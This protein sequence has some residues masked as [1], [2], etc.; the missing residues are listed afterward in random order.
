MSRNPF[1]LT[2]PSACYGCPL[3]VIG[4]GFSEPEGTGVSGVMGIGEALGEHEARDGYPF[5]P[6]AEAGSLLNRACGMAQVPRE[7]LS[8][9][10]IIACRPPA[11]ELVGAGYEQAAIAHCRV[12][13]EAAIDRYKPKVLLALGATAARALTGLTGDRLTLEYIRGFVLDSNVYQN[14]TGSSAGSHGMAGSSVDTGSLSP[15]CTP[16]IS[17]YHPSFI[18]RSNYPMLPVL[19]KDIHDAAEVAKEV[20]AWGHPLKNSVKELRY[21]TDAQPEDLETLRDELKANPDIVLSTDAETNYAELKEEIFKEDPELTEVSI[22]KIE[23]MRRLEERKQE[24]TQVNFS[25]QEGTAVVA[26]ATPGNMRLVREI[27][28]LPNVKAGHNLWMFDW[29]VYEDNGIPLYGSLEDTEDTMWRFHWLYPDLPGKRGK[30]NT[31]DG[32]EDGSVANLQFCASFYGFPIPW[33]HLSGSD[34]G[35]YGGCDGDS[36]LRVFW[37]TEQDMLGLSIREAYYKRLPRL[38]QALR[39]ARKRGMPVNAA[40]LLALHRELVIDIGSIDQEIQKLAPRDVLPLHPATGLKK[41]PK[42]AEDGMVVSVRRKK[43]KETIFI[44]ATLIQIDVDLPA[45]T[46]VCCM[47]ARKPARKTGVIDKKYLDHPAAHM[48]GD[49][50]FSPTPNCKKCGGSGTIALPDRTERRWARELPFNA[51]SP[52]QMWDYVHFRGY[53]VGKNS[54]RKFAMDADTIDKLARRYKDPIFGLCGK[55]RQYVKL[56]TTYAGGWMPWADGRVHSQVGPY[57]ASGQLAGRKPNPQN[58]PSLS[59]IGDAKKLME[60]LAE[61]Q[62]QNVG[63]FEVGRIKDKIRQL[64]L[65]TAFRNALWAEAGFVVIEGD[66]GGFHVGTLGFEAGD[67]NYIRLSKIDIHSFFAVVGLL[68]IERADSLLAMDDAELKAKLKWYRKNYTL[69]DG[70]TS[71]ET[72]RNKQAKVA[73]LAYGLGQGPTS[74]FLQNPDSFSGPAEADRVT[75][76]MNATF[77]KEREYRETIP[78]TVKP[79]GY[80]LVNRFGFIRWLYDVQRYDFRKGEWK[81]GDDWEKAIAFN[82]QA[83]AHGHLRECIMICEDAGYNERYGF[84]NTVHDS[85]R[86]HCHESLADECVQNVKLVMEAPSDVML[87]GWDEGRG[88]TFKAE[89]KMGKSWGSD[90]REVG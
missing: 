13:L 65:A 27:H 33:K 12:H 34:P 72:L 41:A 31:T 78:L 38:M 49:V 48:R 5:R 43:G 3:Y 29:D 17:T 47:R 74:L 70:K 90:M 44:S 80:K 59:K 77:P 30:L 83:S 42:G 14:Q 53:Q 22:E 6:Y 15:G 85:L 35:W 45:E 52:A 51:A 55:K 11:N 54:K 20:M 9:F 7:S 84:D 50:L 2:K 69:K 16:V 63:A 76:K 26:Y 39:N 40:G 24:V 57:P 82:V 46:K 66:F 32:A 8:L 61:A 25:I 64:E 62:T 4:Q 60:A 1:R 21:V 68:G 79:N 89:F 81:H 19:A 28:A 75:Q 10:N 56:D 87:C 71:F 67:P 37:G 86:Y 23:L 18:R 88:M 58:V 36:G 73:V